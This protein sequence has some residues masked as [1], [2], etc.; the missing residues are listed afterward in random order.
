MD[1]VAGVSCAGA[2][3]RDGGQR[4]VRG[5]NQTG[6]VGCAAQRHGKRRGGTSGLACALAVCAN[7]RPVCGRAARGDRQ[8]ADR[9]ATEPLDGSPRAASLRQNGQ[10]AHRAQWRR[11][12][13]LHIFRGA[14]RGRRTRRGLAPAQQYS[15]SGAGCG[16]GLD[17]SAAGRFTA[18]RRHRNTTATAPHGRPRARPPRGAPGSDPGHSRVGP[19]PA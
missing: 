4:S 6:V 2:R 15:A 11:A 13:R 14:R 10:R 5:A 9:P 16:A 1:R 19:W 12:P 7:V 17:L 3:H 18:P 8:C